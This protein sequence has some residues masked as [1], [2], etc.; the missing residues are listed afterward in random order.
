M[1]SRLRFAVALAALSIVSARAQQRPAPPLLEGAAED[2]AAAIQA[3]V[4]ESKK[5][6][7]YVLIDF[8]AGWCPDCKVLDAVLREETVA[9]FLN[10]NFRWVVVDVGY[11][12]KHLDV[13]A[14]YR[15]PVDKW[16]PSIVVLDGNGNTVA[17][18]GDGEAVIGG[19][20]PARITRRVQA[21][22][23]RSYLALWAPK[24]R[25]QTLKSATEH[26]VKVTIGLDRDS[27]GAPWLAATFDPVLPNS[28]LYGQEFPMEGVDG[29]GRPT[30]FAVTSTTGAKSL[31]SAVASRASEISRIEALK[32]DLIVYPNGPVTLHIPVELPARGESGKTEVSV[33]YMT[34]GPTGCL[35][36]V[37]DKRIVVDVPQRK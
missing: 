10:D 18:S 14:K 34:C 23:V 37:M 19:L 20:S 8:G 6:G 24:K 2:P 29:A 32:Q 31:G 27:S 13:A 7:K 16:I 26:G 30:R 17:I 15:A 9:P 22:D 1:A 5:D 4:N 12:E 35:P 11:R 3:A 33:T 25:E 21:K 28:Y 36:P